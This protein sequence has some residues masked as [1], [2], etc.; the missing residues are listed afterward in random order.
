L[1]KRFGIDQKSDEKIAEGSDEKT[2]CFATIPLPTWRIILAANK[3]AE[4]LAICEKGED[5]FYDYMIAL[6]E[7]AGELDVESPLKP[8]A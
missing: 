1:K 4:V 8:A 2:R 3:R 6:T 5:A 7:A